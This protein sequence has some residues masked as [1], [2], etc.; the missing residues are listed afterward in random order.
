MNGSIH[1]MWTRSTFLCHNS[2][3]TLASHPWDDAHML[4]EGATRRRILEVQVG[5]RCGTEV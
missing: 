4:P 2:N 1:D 3:G 5:F